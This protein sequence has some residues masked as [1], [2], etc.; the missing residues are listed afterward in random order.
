MYKTCNVHLVQTKEKA[1]IGELTT[2][3]TDPKALFIMSKEVYDAW[4]AMFLLTDEKVGGKHLRGNHLIITSDD[5]L[6]IGDLMFNTEDEHILICES[7]RYLNTG[8]WKKIIAATKSL[9]K[10]LP[11]LPENWIEHFIR[12]YESGNKITKVQIEYDYCG[13]HDN[14]VLGREKLATTTDGEFMIMGFKLKTTDNN[15]IIIKIEPVKP[16]LFLYTEDE[17]KEMCGKLYFESQASFHTLKFEE[18]FK[19]NKK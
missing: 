12:E 2:N 4:E 10:S 6:S 3:A 13:I 9:N 14:N 18:W 16:I 8:R 19:Q 7:L 17:V 5:K 1:K 15:E 11:K